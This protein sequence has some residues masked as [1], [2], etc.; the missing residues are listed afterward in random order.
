MVV[1]LCEILFNKIIKAKS[2]TMESY[3]DSSAS[4]AENYSVAK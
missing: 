3:D 2:I 4:T 1:Q